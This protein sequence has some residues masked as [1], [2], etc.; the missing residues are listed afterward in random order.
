MLG[1]GEPDRIMTILAGIGVIL[2]ALHTHRWVNGRFLA[3]K[4]SCRP[5][6]H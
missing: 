2:L 5:S 6:I 4:V 1:K 3:K